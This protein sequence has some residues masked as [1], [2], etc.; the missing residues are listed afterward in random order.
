MLG[1]AGVVGVDGVL[2]EGG[3]LE[4][5]RALGAGEVRAGMDAGRI[6]LAVV[7]FDLADPGQHAPGQ[8]RAGL[9]RGQVQGQVGGRDAREG[10]RC[11]A[12][13]QAGAGLAGRG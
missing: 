7:A 11:R 8:A 2:G 3:G 12:A 5:H 13:G 6:R 1:L 10:Q 4:L 9:R